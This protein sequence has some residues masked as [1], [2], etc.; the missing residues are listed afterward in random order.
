MTFIGNSVSTPKQPQ[1]YMAK[2]PPNLESLPGDDDGAQNRRW[3]WPRVRNEMGRALHSR[4]GCVAGGKPS[5][6]ARYSGGGVATPPGRRGRAVRDRENSTDAGRT[7]A[8]E[9][10]GQWTRWRR[11]GFRVGP[12]RTRAIRGRDVAGAAAARR[13]RW[14]A[15]PAIDFIRSAADAAMAREVTVLPGDH[16]PPGDYGPPGGRDLA[17]PPDAEQ[18]LHEAVAVLT[19]VDLKKTPRPNCGS[20]WRPC[21]AASRQPRQPTILLAGVNHADFKRAVKLLEELV[22]ESPDATNIGTIWC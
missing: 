2:P 1:T 3:L 5:P 7:S 14:A 11:H 22:A 6:G 12:G 20:C 9:F 15:I 10:A 17:A 4:W 18:R 21:R 16:G 13:Y 8:A 19:D